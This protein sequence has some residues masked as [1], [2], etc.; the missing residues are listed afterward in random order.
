MDSIP[1][2]EDIQRASR[3]LLDF[4]SPTMLAPNEPTQILQIGLAPNRVDVL[5]DVGPL[6]FDDAWA[7]RG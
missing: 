2:F 1:D 3:A 7:R 6:S 5:V 4:G